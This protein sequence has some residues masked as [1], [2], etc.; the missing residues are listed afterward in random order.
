MRHR[1]RWWLV[2][3]LAAVLAAA[4]WL[5]T[6]AAAWSWL[7]AAACVAAIALLMRR[8]R[9]PT[10]LLGLAL[11]IMAAQLIVTQWNLAAIERDWP[12]QREAR[13]EAYGERVDGELRAALREAVRLAALGADAAT[14]ERGEAFERLAAATPTTGI[15]R[16]I[17]ILDSVG[18]P[19][20]WAGRHR[21]PA[22]P[23]GDSIA[24]RA[25]PYYV[26]LETRRHSGDR[27]AVASVLIWADSAVADRDRSLA[28]R[29]RRATEVGLLVYPPGTAPEGNT[30]IF[31]Y[32]EPTTEGPRLLF[33]VQPVP[34]QQEE[35]RTRVYDRGANAVLWLALA[36]LALA[37]FI[38]PST[39]DRALVIPAF[40]W[41]TAR[42]PIGQLLGVEQGFSRGT[43]AHPLLGT[44]TGSPAALIL[45]GTALA[46]LAGLA[47]K[48]PPQRRRA[49]LVAAMLLAIAAPVAVSLLAPAVSPPASGTPLALW[50]AWQCGLML[51]GAP[52]ALLAGALA[53]QGATRSSRWRTL[54]GV[55]IALLLSA[56]AMTVWRPGIAWPVWLPLAWALPLLLTIAGAPRFSA[57]I[58]SAA[59]LG[60]LAACLTWNADI[61]AR[62]E[63]AEADVARLG[64]D[65]DP[66]AAALLERFSD[67]VGE[68]APGSAAAL[69]TLWRTSPLHA[70]GYPVHLALWTSEGGPIVDL[71]IDSLA[72]PRETLGALARALPAG[73]PSEIRNLPS[74]PGV[75]HVLVRHIGTD[76]VLTVAVG[77]RSALVA[78]DRLGRLL[79]GDVETTP[80][81]RLTLGSPVAAVQPAAPLLWRR[82]GW[83]LR[84][85][86]AIAL[87][88]GPRQV[89]ARVEL[90]DPARLAVR[91]I[92]LL[93]LNAILLGA[94]VLA[95]GALLAPERPGSPGWRRIAGSFRLRLALALAVF[96]VLPTVAFAA[97]SF[98]HFGEEAERGR[99]LLITQTLRDAAQGAGALL[100]TPGVPLTEALRRLS[101]RVD[102]D[103][104]LYRGGALVAT[105]APLLS[106]LGVVPPLMDAS[107]FR[108]LA[109]EGE[110]E[111]TR[112]GIMPELA[113]RVGYRV[114]EFAPSGGIGVLATP[115]V[116]GPLDP[117]GQQFELALVLLLATVTG[118]VAAIAAAGVASRALSR[119][120]A[121]LRRAAVAVGQGKTPPL[122]GTTPPV[123]FEPVFGAFHRM[124][125][126]VRASQR[127]LEESRR[128]TAAVL[129]TVAT[130][131]IALDPSGAVLV[132][133][134]QAT[135]L[136]GVPL[137]EGMQLADCLTGDWEPLRDALTSILADPA[138]PGDSFE[139]SADLRRVSVQVAALGGD[140]SGV[141]LALTDVTHLSRAER[142]LAWGEMAR[143]VAHEI[144]N[145]LTP[146][147]LGIQHL[148]RVY[149]DRRENFAD[150]LD[151]TSR[152]ILGEIDRLDT[153]ARAFSRFAVPGEEAPPAQRVDLAAIAAEVAQLYQL[154]GEGTAVRYEAKGPVWGLARRDEVKEVL[155]NLFENARNAGARTITME[156]LPG[157]IRIADDG[158]GMPAELLPRIFEPRFSTTTS[159]SG[160]GL[161]IVRRL[162]E[163]WGGTVS[164]ESEEGTGTIVRVGIPVSA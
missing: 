88:G 6:P 14:L 12:A 29:F 73:T 82:A 91:G 57:V 54:A 47:W 141:V 127:A 90:Q 37:V 27:I 136:L 124:A 56:A 2:V 150:T 131:V 114:I 55:A 89:L 77:P 102:A 87:P 111:T 25:D 32:E 20:A 71:P 142:V 143:Q 15:E 35:A 21:L 93:L 84:A 51:A 106:E 38:A 164:V 40:L 34:P 139:L 132:A 155:V 109:L 42:A 30:D 4:E 105:S 11:G 58:G 117:E 158:A 112:D 31:D 10:A 157:E 145:P 81:Y 65:P 153:I 161:A 1:S 154:A 126:D 135:D 49:G 69:Y 103:L 99:D 159:G 162:V 101:D 64:S 83:T 138:R 120:V 13:I 148:Q 98:S 60:S 113:E 24:V 80:T 156:V 23:E 97:W 149:R 147:R 52:L 122:P 104:S 123:E 61:G 19:W 16:G 134:R 107:A 3:V 53:G 115:Q 96:F 79:A 116:S 121:E 163:S 43:F 18:S 72:L 68:S 28:E 50:V 33:S 7:S 119:P 8:A 128:R 152:R 63:R 26:L 74:V 151:E 48:R 66:Q 45:T 108:T 62:L 92:L 36:A 144:K 41:L 78:R 160:L 140:L 100:R 130:G 22:E 44:L 76:R 70:R 110:V 94:I 146:V 129:A 67:A 9:W 59:V 75:H 85:E 5:R 46:L 17:V 39:V 125:A 95:A 133:N 86:R 137:R 118:I